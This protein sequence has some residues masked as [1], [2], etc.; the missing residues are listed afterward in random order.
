MAMI[1]C[2]F[3]VARILEKLAGFFVTLSMAAAAGL[4]WLCRLQLVFCP[5]FVHRSGMKGGVGGT[6]NVSGENRS[7]PC[8]V[9]PNGCDNTPF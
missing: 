8:T 4:A 3:L 2:Q 7:T 5:A 6:S 1:S 9:G